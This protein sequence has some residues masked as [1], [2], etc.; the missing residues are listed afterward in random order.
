MV[1]ELLLRELGVRKISLLDVDGNPQEYQINDKI[2]LS[3]PEFDPFRRSLLMV[4]Q[5]WRRWNG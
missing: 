1:D 4:G 3:V 2:E 5:A